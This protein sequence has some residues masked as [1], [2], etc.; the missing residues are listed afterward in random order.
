VIVAVAAV[1]V[2]VAVV[3]VA[4]VAVATTTNPFLCEP[5]KACRISAGF[6]HF[7][8]TDWAE[9]VVEAFVFLLVYH[10]IWM[11]IACSLAFRICLVQVAVCLMFVPRFFRSVA[12]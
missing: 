10:A 11:K 7:Q 5:D 12:C 4:M 8:D 3:A 6:F 1:A 9:S 2:V